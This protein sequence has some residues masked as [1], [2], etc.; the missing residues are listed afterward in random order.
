MAEASECAAF[1]R[2]DMHLAQAST[3]DASH[4]QSMP[5]S[6]AL[7]GIVTRTGCRRQVDQLYFPSLAVV[8]PVA[9]IEASLVRSPYGSAACIHLRPASQNCP[10]IRHSASARIP[11]QAWEPPPCSPSFLMTWRHARPS[12]RVPP[13]L[14][15]VLPAPEVC[16]AGNG[17]WSIGSRVFLSRVEDRYSGKGCPIH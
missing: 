5:G 16:N 14:A 7:S 15:A 4:R 3:P 13:E 12:P 11:S 10:A 1:H 8:K 2:D 9:R 17:G 6:P